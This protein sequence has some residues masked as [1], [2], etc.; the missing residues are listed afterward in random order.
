MNIHEKQSIEYGP[1]LPPCV[2]PVKDRDPET[3]YLYKGDVR[4]WN[5]KK[6]MKMGAQQEIDKVNARARANAWRLISNQLGKPRDNIQNFKIK[7]R[8]RAKQWAK[9]NPEKYKTNQKAI[10]GIPENKVR[11]KKYNAAYNAIPANKDKLRRQRRR[12]RNLRKPHR[13]FKKF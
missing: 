7:N 2:P 4:Y 3:Y 12:Y 9:N 5:G 10:R 8:I 1:S 6:L 11:T 13:N